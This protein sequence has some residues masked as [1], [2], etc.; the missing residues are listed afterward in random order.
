MKTV[1]FFWE[2][3]AL[4]ESKKKRRGAE[5]RVMNFEAKM[6]R[7]VIMEAERKRWRSEEVFRRG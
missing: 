1:Y 4:R 6:T 5:K 3:G 2:G 7:G